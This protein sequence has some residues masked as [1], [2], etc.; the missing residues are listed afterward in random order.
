MFSRSKT[1]IFGYAFSLRVNFL[2]G[3]ICKNTIGRL[4][5]AETTSGNMRKKGRPNPD[6]K[7]FF[8]VASCTAQ[9]ENSDKS[10]PIVSHASERIIVRA[11]NPGTVN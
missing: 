2:N 11:S 4:H 8:L 3:Q 9:I 7:Y 10:Y 6:Q 5:F 1:L